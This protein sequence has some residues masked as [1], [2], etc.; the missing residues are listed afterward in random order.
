MSRER[1]LIDIDHL[2]TGYLNGRLAERRHWT[3]GS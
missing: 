1:M 3:A 2:L